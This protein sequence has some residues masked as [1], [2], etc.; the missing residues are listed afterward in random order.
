ML[1]SEGLGGIHFLTNCQKVCSCPLFF[2]PVIPAATKAALREPV[3][4]HAPRRAG[5]VWGVTL[6]RP[7]SYNTKSAHPTDLSCPRQHRER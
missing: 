6:I 3:K 5:R 1:L 7:E 2:H 4:T